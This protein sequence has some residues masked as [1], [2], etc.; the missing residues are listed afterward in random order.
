MYKNTWDSDNDGLYDAYCCI[1][2]SDALQYNSGAVTLLD[3][4]L[5]GPY[6]P[7]LYFVGLMPKKLLK[8]L[9]K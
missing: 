1:W 2:A 3:M 5:K 8:S 9:L 6:F 7:A 4:H